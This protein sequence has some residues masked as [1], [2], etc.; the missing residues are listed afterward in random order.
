MLNKITDILGSVRF[1]QLLVAAVLQSLVLFEIINGAQAEGL[2][3]IIS[4]LLVGSVAV[5]TLDS[6][7]VKSAPKTVIIEAPAPDYSSMPLE[8]LASK[9]K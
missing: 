9:I 3:D 4:T 2:I 6:V 7:A 1:L 8:E 5:G